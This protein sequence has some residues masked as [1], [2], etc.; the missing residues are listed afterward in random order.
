MRYLTILST[1]ILASYA[2]LANTHPTSRSP[3]LLQRSN[4]TDALRNPSFESTTLEPWEVYTSGSWANHEIVTGRGHHAE[5]FFGALSNSTN[6]STITLSQSFNFP[7]G[8]VECEAWVMA[9]GD[10]GSVKVEAFVNGVKFDEVEM[11]KKKGWVRLA[12]RISLQG[13]SHMIVLV[14]TVNAEGVVGSGIGV[15]FDDVKVYS[16]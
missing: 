13:Y 16:C 14:G 10:L 8:D 11:R 2:I 5:H 12:G 15:G 6:A 1:L 7:T 3:S 9:A 4:C